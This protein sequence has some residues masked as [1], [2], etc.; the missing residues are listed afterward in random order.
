MEEE[1]DSEETDS[2]EKYMGRKD[3][4]SEEDDNGEDD[5]ER[6]QEPLVFSVYDLGEESGE[7][8]QEFVFAR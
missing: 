3:D 4:D 5:H 6:P 2:L 8:E 1:A 7:E